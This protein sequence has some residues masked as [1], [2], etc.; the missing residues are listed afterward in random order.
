ML[1]WKLLTLF[2]TTPYVSN[3]IIMQSVL[4]GMLHIEAN[5][6]KAQTSLMPTSWLSSSQPIWILSCH[7]QVSPRGTAALLTSS[8]NQSR[9]KISLTPTHKYFF[10]FTFFYRMSVYFRE[11]KYSTPNTLIDL[12]W[13]CCSPNTTE[14]HL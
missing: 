5:Q 11:L 9:Q 6:I 4:K 1:R 8:Q 14:I 10:S 12:K 3:W 13:M 2:L 7:L